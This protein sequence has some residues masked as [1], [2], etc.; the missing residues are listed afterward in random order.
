MPPS[1]SDTLPRPIADAERSLAPDLGRGLMLALVALANSVIYLYD[2]PYGPRQHIVEHDTLDR[3][4]AF[5][6]TVLVE[7]RGYPLFAAL[8]AYGIVRAHIRHRS[9]GLDDLAARRLLRRR[10][11]WLIVFGAAHAVLLF[12]G[13]VLGLY[14]LL[15]MVLLAMLK[16]GDRALLI[17]GAAWLA[18]CGLVQG[19]VYSDSGPNTERT[20][21]WSFAVDDVPLAIALRAVEWIFTPLGLAGVFSAALAGMWAARRDIL[22]APRE[23]R[24][25]LRR[26]AFTGITVST[27]GG[28]PMGLMVAGVWTETGFLT[29]YLAS[30]LHVITGVAGG[31]G[32]AALIGLAAIRLGTR[33]GPVATALAACGQRSLTCYLLQ[34]VAFAALFAPYTLGLG[35]RLGSAATA[36]VAIAVWLLTVAIA[37]AMRRTGHRGPAETLLRRL[38]YPKP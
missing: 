11:R 25:L 35:A 37:E 29:D 22:G 34:S 36:G 18:V 14:G 38:S 23:H 32:Y 3:V 9:R 28:V 8:F 33:R 7:I 20:F 10:G 15:G 26:V 27:A 16:V 1:T 13:D 2:R 24:G 4:V 19:L 6:N 31:L 5:L 17:T 12:S 30:A 21:F